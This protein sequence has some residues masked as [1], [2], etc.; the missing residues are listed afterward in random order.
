MASQKLTIHPCDAQR[1]DHAEHR[2]LILRCAICDVCIFAD[3]ACG[4]GSR[5]GVGPSATSAERYYRPTE[6]LNEKSVTSL[7]VNTGG[8]SRFKRWQVR[9]TLLKKAAQ[10]ARGSP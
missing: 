1:W 9:P 5:H 4:S 3:P 8:E 7:E 2:E 6:K 10:S